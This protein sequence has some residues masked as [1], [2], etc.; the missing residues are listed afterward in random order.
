MALQ[1]EFEH[2]F[3]AV[4]SHRKRGGR[5]LGDHKIDGRLRYRLLEHKVVAGM[6]KVRA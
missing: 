2:S 3:S 5:L 1:Q 4:S 6:A